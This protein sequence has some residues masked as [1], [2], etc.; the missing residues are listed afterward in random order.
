VSIVPIS[1]RRARLALIL[2]LLGVPSIGVTLPAA[3]WLGVGAVRQRTLASGAEPVTGFLA[4][5]IA[6]I[7]L[8]FIDQGLRRV[9]AVTTEE[10]IW[11]GIG[12]G[13]VLAT[14]VLVLVTTSLR[15]HPERSGAVLATRAG[16]VASLGGGTA[17]FVRLLG[18]IQT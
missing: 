11:A 5:V 7:D 8:L 1:D 18:V 2:A 10:T 16:L 4:L 14:S 9:F 15:L 3:V 17:M 6:G 12:L 13:L